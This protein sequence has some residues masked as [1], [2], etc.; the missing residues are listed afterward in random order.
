MKVGQVVRSRP[1]RTGASFKQI[2]PVGVIPEITGNRYNPS[3]P[4]KTL[5]VMWS[6]PIR[7]FRSS[8]AVTSFD[9]VS[10]HEVDLVED[11]Q[12]D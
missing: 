10:A 7:S 5:K 3:D 1:H 6:Q 12:D 9:I 11:E 8:G 2:R 4:E